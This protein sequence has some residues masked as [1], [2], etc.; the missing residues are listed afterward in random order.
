MNT[1]LALKGDTEDDRLVIID[2][3]LA[4]G[5][6]GLAARNDRLSIDND[7]LAAKINKRTDVDDES[8]A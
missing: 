2:D 7:K 5:D 3:G 8:N 4:A 6:D 1:R